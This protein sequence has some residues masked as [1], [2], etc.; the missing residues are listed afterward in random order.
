MS[1]KK[2]P[3]LSFFTG[4]GLLDIGFLEQGFKIVWHNEKF[5][6]FVQAFEAGLSSLGFKGASATIQNKQSIVEVGPNTILNEA[7]NSAKPPKLFGIIGGPPC[8]DFSVGG[9]NRGKLGEQGKLSEVF[10]NRIVELNPTFF[11]FEN[12]PGLLRTAKHRDFLVTLL[13]KVSSRFSLDLRILNALDLGVP[14][15]R[16]R[17]FIVGFKNS[18]LRSNL[19]P[20]SFKRIKNASEFVRLL[21]KLP[22]KKF[23]TDID[24][25]FPWPE[26]PAYK[27]AKYR[28]DWPTDNVPKGKVPTKPDCPPELMVGNYICDKKRLLLKNSSEGFRPKSNKFKVILEGDV[29]R[30]SFKRLHRY[31]Y[32][33]AAAYGNNEVHL[34]PELPRRLTVREAMMIQSIPD[35]YILPENMT[36]TDKFKTI[37][38]GVPVKLASA[39]AGS[40]A[41][42]LKEGRHE[43]I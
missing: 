27:G 5:L 14:Q 10:F 33:P 11:L 36:L 40:F 18:W 26:E 31:R 3:I 23:F 15:D 41:Y 8:P 4:A 35:E 29:S 37:G 7:F 17:I 1:L 9:K 34:H 16:E 25:W 42:F 12:V 13:D 21:S 28:F 43:I 20:K 38:N 22:P 19:K 24:H 2:I 32:S 30:K 6:P 39:I